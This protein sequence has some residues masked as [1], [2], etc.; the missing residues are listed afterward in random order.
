M[1]LKISKQIDVCDFGSEMITLSL[2]SKFQELN[3]FEVYKILVS[4]MLGRISLRYQKNF[5]AHICNYKK[6]LNKFNIFQ[7]RKRMLFFLKKTPMRK[8]ILLL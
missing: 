4:S 8:K 5:T 6:R 3:A 7:S 2:G 1:S